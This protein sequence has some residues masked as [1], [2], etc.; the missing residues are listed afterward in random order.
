MADTE[1]TETPAQA[2]VPQQP[3]A[4][5]AAG[6]TATGQAE[7]AEDRLARLEHELTETRKEA[8][9]YRT[10]LRSQEQQQQDA[11]RKAAEESGQFKTLYEQSQQKIAELERTQAAQAQAD[12]RRKAAR[13]AGLSED[14][15]DRLR[16]ETPEELLADAK[17]LAKRLQPAAPSTGATNPGR[18]GDLSED[19]QIEA[20]F[21][22][23]QR[24]QRSGMKW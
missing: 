9:K 24:S 18:R 13:D 14:L 6:A 15:A 20:M 12:A 7:S 8:A 17:A 23:G 21:K 4:Q 16:G 2:A 3:A 10:T 5:A 22:P 19:E 11:Q 1:T